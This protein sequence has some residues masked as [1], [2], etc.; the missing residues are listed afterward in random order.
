GDRWETFRWENPDF[1]MKSDEYDAA[2]ILERCNNYMPKLEDM[3]TQ[4][5]NCNTLPLAISTTEL[6]EMML[7]HVEQIRLFAQFRIGL[8]KAEQWLAEGASKTELERIIREI[9]TPIPEYN[10]LIGMWGQ[11]EARTQCDM[12]ETFCEK[13]G[14]EMPKDPVFRFYRKQRIYQ[15]FCRYQK[16]KQEKYLFDR[17]NGFQMG[18][19][20]GEKDSLELTEELIADGLLS[21][22]EEGRVYVTDWENY[23]YHFGP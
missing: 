6:L 22:D 21:E 11:M 2:D 4:N 18:V 8:E 17:I 15:E 16:G 14:I 5:L 13:A 19:A 9:Y 1:I 20:F 23:R 7:P 3:I 10:T 12:L